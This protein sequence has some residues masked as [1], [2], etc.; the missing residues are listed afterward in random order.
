VDGIPFCINAIPDFYVEMVCLTACEVAISS[1]HSESVESF[2]INGNRALEDCL[3]VRYSQTLDLKTF[4][5]DVSVFV[6]EL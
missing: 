4:Q 1:V 5:I 2:S 6:M 3:V